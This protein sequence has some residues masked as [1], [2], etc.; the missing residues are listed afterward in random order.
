MWVLQFAFRP[1]SK[2]IPVSF[3]RNDFSM[4]RTDRWTTPMVIRI[5]NAGPAF[6]PNLYL[7]STPVPW[8]I[9]GE[10]LKVEL[11]RRADWTVYVRGDDNISFQYV[12]LVIDTIQ[13]EHAKA[14]LLTPNTEKLVLG[15][16][17]ETEPPGRASASKH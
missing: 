9:L 7:N 3:L 15:Q 5:K 1:I 8:Q 12:A 2:G 17:S 14:V 10:A 11:A 13:G 4:A 6:R 16:Q